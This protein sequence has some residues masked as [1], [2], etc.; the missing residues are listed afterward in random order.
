MSSRMAENRT[1]ICQV[2]ET[3]KLVL[4][5]LFN[6]F[7]D[8]E[9]TND[10][11]SLRS[12]IDRV[13]NFCLN[14]PG[15]DQPPQREPISSSTQHPVVLTTVSRPSAPANATPTSREKNIIIHGL[16][17]SHSPDDITNENLEEDIRLFFRNKLNINI[18]PRSVKLLG[19]SERKP[20]RIQL[21][22]AN[23]KR[24]IFRN[25]YKL[26]ST[27]PYVT[28]VD[29]FSYQERWRRKVLYSAMNTAKT[30]GH[31]VRIKK[32]SLYID[33]VLAF[34]LPPYPEP[35]VLIKHTSCSSSQ[36]EPAVNTSVAQAESSSNTDP[37]S[38]SARVSRFSSLRSLWSYSKKRRAPLP[39]SIAQL[40]H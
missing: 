26:K 9:S 5:A 22:S 12:E 31:Q 35:A 16:V 23:D 6:R 11:I 19:K 3:Q 1:R 38:P 39:P 32:D 37:T 13:L 14:K 17:P 29:D 40:V 10:L 36:P 7:T 24:A 18:E 34:T 4:S 20:F 15:K 27:N 25:C 28:I 30:D 21:W 2:P 8:S 33:G